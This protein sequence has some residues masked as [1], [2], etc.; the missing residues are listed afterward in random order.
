[1]FLEIALNLAMWMGGVL[2]VAFEDLVAAVGSNKEIDHRSVA[3]LLSLELFTQ[4]QVVTSPMPLQD[5]TH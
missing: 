3:W 2:G 1:M 5:S 4:N